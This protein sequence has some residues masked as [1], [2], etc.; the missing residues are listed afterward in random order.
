MPTEKTKSSSAGGTPGTTKKNTPKSSSPSAK[1]TKPT[2]P[3][4][5][6]SSSSCAC[7]FSNVFYKAVRLS[8]VSAFFVVLLFAALIAFVDLSPY[9]V[10]QP[11]VLHQV[12]KEVLQEVHQLSNNTSA[13]APLIEK[14]VPLLVEKLSQ[15]Y[16][17]HINK[18]QEWVFNNAGGA[19]GVL[20]I[21]HASI[22]E[23]VIIFGTPIGT[24]GHTGR[25]AADDY[26]I[27]LDGEQWAFS[28]G[29]YRKEV[30]KPGE[31]HHLPRGHAQA[32]RAPDTM[33]ALEYAQGWIP[34]MLPFGVADTLTSTLDVHTLAQTFWL[35]AKLVVRELLLGKI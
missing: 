17:N 1:Q 28:A 8:F 31:M 11:N 32:Y 20:Y 2:K 10:F 6:S 35:Y 15:R 34:A 21:L 5:S 18:E 26:F 14:M 19:M 25:F 13:D 30:Y 3:V 23:Y 7:S 9:Y 33:W 16:P 24:E 29:S 27:I 12:A 4:A 22:S